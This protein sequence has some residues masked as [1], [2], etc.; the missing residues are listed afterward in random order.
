MIRSSLLCAFLIALFCAPAIAQNLP[1]GSGF[2]MVPIETSSRNCIDE[3]TYRL[4][5][6]VL[7]SRSPEANR[8]LGLFYPSYAWPFEK[9][10]GDRLIML[11]YVDEDASSD[12]IDYEGGYHSYD[13]HNGTDIG[14]FDFRAMDEGTE[15]LSAGEG[16]VSYVDHNQPDR[17]TVWSN[18]SRPN[19]VVVQN[20][21]G[22]VA[23]YLHFRK[24]SLTVNVG[25]TVRRGDVLG[26]VGSS[27]YSNVAHLHF[28]TGEYIGSTWT[29]RDPWNGPQNPKPGLWASQAPYVGADPIRIYD[30]G[31]L[32]RLTA[33]SN[34]NNI[35]SE[36]FKERL[37]GPAVMGASEQS[38]AV[39]ILL[40]CQAGDNYSFEVRRPDNSLYATSPTNTIQW[41]Y[42]LG[43][44]YWYTNFS[45]GVSASDYGTWKV[46]AKANGEVARTM[47][48]QV[49]P[50]TEYAPHFLPLAGRS[51][52]ITGTRQLDTLRTWHPSGPVTYSLLNA[53]SFIKLS[54]DSIITIPATSSQSR[55]WL[56]FQAVATD[57]AGR[58]DTM[59]Y[60]LV[61]P[62]KPYG[63]VGSG[64][65]TLITSAHDVTVAPNP[66]STT[67]TISYT[68]DAPA[69]VSIRISD[70]I[71]REV[72]RSEEMMQSVG[73]HNAQIDLSS[74]APGTY[75]FHVKI[76]AAVRSGKLVKGEG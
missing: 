13:G 32:T 41:S 5:A 65:A 39:W 37:V 31:L 47:N 28:E 25:D 21:D 7:Q 23:W 55:R 60:H 58:S 62:S 76:G 75:F 61:D 2:G 66:S 27:G 26:L 35:P 34:I 71:G 40:Q 70:A 19:Q 68:L 67:T 64:V 44:F 69:M 29:R 12:V 14:L 10:Q 57:A 45:G 38:L 52:Y 24:H 59:H 49:G 30:M 72:S 73:E 48:F 9:P 1:D 54:N 8:S 46:I 50:T 56:Y 18:D 22:T 63:K 3:E 42:N 36:M 20:G 16:V 15:V 51:F 74:L 33:G 53:P 4:L 11:N 43:W 17:N 6:P